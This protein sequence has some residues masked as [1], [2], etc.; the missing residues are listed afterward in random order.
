MKR[1]LVLVPMMIAVIIFLSQCLNQ[2]SKAPVQKASVTAGLITHKEMVDSLRED[3]TVALKP[4]IFKILDNNAK[5]AALRNINLDS[6]FINS[7]PDN[8]FYGEDRYRIEFV[9][10]EATRDEADPSVY[11]IKGKNR[12]KKTITNFEG[13][14]RITDLRSFTDPNMDS[15][16]VAESNFKNLY[17]AKGVFEFK[18]DSAMINTSGLFKGT[19]QMEFADKKTEKPE[20][21]FYSAGMYAT[22]GRGTPGYRLDGTWTSFKNPNMVKPVIWARDL[23]SFANDILKDFAM[24]ERDVEIS[25][26]YRDLGWADF[27]ENEE[28]WNETPK[29]KM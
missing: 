24:G 10:T 4:L 23:F 17:T 13:T 28:W 8:G 7:Y 27:W 9:F 26:Q 29:E 22:D 5:Q 19:L 3:S 25:P 21:W 18:E 12:H 15:A 1:S 2:K 14:L 20:L 11:H 6:L 16:Y